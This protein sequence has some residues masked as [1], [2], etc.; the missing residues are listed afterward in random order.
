MRL[1]IKR[2]RKQSFYTLLAGTLLSPRNIFQQA[3]YL[4]TISPRYLLRVMIAISS[5]LIGST[6]RIAEDLRYRKRLKLTPISPP[7]IFIVGH[8]RSGT[9]HLH[10]LLSLD[11][12]FSFTTMYQA[13]APGCTLIGGH[14]LKAIL[15]AFLPQSRPMDNVTW[16]MDTPQEDEIP[17]GKLG[18][19]SAYAMW[20][21]PHNSIEIAKKSI[22]FDG[23]FEKGRSDF[24]KYY[25][26]VLRVSSFAGNGRQLLLK[27][28]ANTGRISTLVDAFPGAKFIHI[29]RSPYEVYRST[30][31]LHREAWKISTLQTLKG[32]SEREIVLAVYELVMRAFLRDRGAIPAESYIDVRYEDLEADPI[33]VLSGIYEKLSI[34]GFPSVK[35]DLV[36]YVESIKHYKKNELPLSSDDIRIVNSRLA[37][38]FEAL[39]Y[40]MISERDSETS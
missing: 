17:I 6:L 27:N 33:K 29:H 25:T 21:F 18:G 28:P 26:K 32:L 7:P 34:P 37:F 14:A 30:L 3:H 39:G 24:L 4:P 12:Q 16:S 20:F 8:W 31:H 13:V 11:K 1:L 22:L 2:V 10:N 19:P 15:A 36:S 38:A 9:T 23:D 40:S 35:G 5:G